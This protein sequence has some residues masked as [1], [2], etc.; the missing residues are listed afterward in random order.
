MKKLSIFNKIGV[1][2]ILFAFATNFHCCGLLVMAD[3][4]A[5]SLNCYKIGYRLFSTKCPRP[6]KVYDNADTPKY[7][8]C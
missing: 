6:A 3:L 4:N 1:S 2:S 5:F 8:N 7:L